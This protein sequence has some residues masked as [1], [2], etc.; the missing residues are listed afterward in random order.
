MILKIFLFWRLLLFVVVYFGSFLLPRMSNSAIGAV[1]QDKSFD[2]WL[3]WAQWD[4]GHYLDIAKDG[5][6]QGSDFAFFPLYPL[7]IK[8]IAPLFQEN[9]LLSGLL[10]SNLAFVAFLYIFFKLVSKSHSPK[11][12][13][14]ATVTF[15]VFPTTFFAVS[16]YSESLFLL[17]TTLTF[18]FLKDKKYLL[19]SIAASLAS[20][21]KATG[22]ILAISIFYSYLSRINFDLRRLNR[23]F[24]AIFPSVAGILTY[25]FYLTI[26]TG[27]PFK[28]LAIQSLWQRSIIDPIS[29]I[30]A[31]IWRL[32]IANPPINDYFDLAITL[33]FLLI[34]I[35][36]R[37]VISSSLWIFSILVILIPLS[38]GILTSMPRY[39]L[40]SLGAFVIA[41]TYLEKKPH[42]KVP[43]W[44]LSLVIQAFGAIFFVNG[45]WVA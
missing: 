17:I 32:F 1:G 24:V 11:I 20:L 37:R 19:A 2:Y 40:A 12:A 45:H 33:S 44:S 10:I 18:L 28:F 6:L 43:I 7:F 21:T 26:Y 41:A 3:S 15:L 23:S 35:L 16:L 29:T 30:F 36:G 4:G 5:Y 42:L 8:L 14:S 22:A 25:G 39:V 31:Y 13:F 34:L 9:F 27:D 38:T